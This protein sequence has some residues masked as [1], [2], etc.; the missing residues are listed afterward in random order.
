MIPQ[1]EHLRSADSLRSLSDLTWVAINSSEWRSS[2]FLSLSR[3][4]ITDHSGLRISCA[5]EYS[6]AVL[7]SIFI[8]GVSRSIYGTH[9]QCECSLYA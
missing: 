4:P 3:R 2:I 8:A 7:G 1:F 5:I 6:N 9:V